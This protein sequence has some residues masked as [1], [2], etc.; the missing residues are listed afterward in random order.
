M[1]KQVERVVAFSGGRSHQYYYQQSVGAGSVYNPMIFESR[2]KDRFPPMFC[3]VIT[4]HVAEHTQHTLVTE[5]YDRP[6]HVGTHWWEL[7][8]GNPPHP[9]GQ[10]EGLI[11]EAAFAAAVYA[12]SAALPQD[13]ASAA[14]HSDCYWDAEGWTV[15]RHCEQY[16]EEAPREDAY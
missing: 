14:E 2:R 7:D 9:K 3:R 10:E 5:G 13:A 1:S 4:D 6:V 11:G 16:P 12:A 8:D 15:Y